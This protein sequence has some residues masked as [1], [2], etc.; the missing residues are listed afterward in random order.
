MFWVFLELRRKNDGA[1]AIT[2][3]TSHALSAHAA[4]G[5]HEFGGDLAGAPFLDAQAMLPMHH[6]LWRMPLYVAASFEGSHT[7]FGQTLTSTGEDDMYLAKLNA[8]GDLMWLIQ[9]LANRD[10]N[11]GDLTLMPVRDFA[12]VAWFGENETIYMGFTSSS[13]E[14][15]TLGHHKIRCSNQR[16]MQSFLEG[17]TDA[18]PVISSPIMDKRTTHCAFISPTGEILWTT[19]G[20]GTAPC[21][22]RCQRQRYSRCLNVK[23]STPSLGPC[24]LSTFEA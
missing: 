10:V 14:P 20:C 13:N 3:P 5:S 9:G 19:C 8:D 23:P 17:S 4:T 22:D 11:V 2:T 16:A 6:F 7:V 12:T 1:A 18:V 21:R 24:L 15:T